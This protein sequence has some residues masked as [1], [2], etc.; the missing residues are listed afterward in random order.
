MAVRALGK[1]N[2]ENF[3]DDAFTRQHVIDKLAHYAELRRQLDAGET[4]LTSSRG[5]ITGFI[6]GWLGTLCELD[7]LFWVP[8]TKKEKRIMGWRN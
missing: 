8:K 4:T 3:Q 7:E 1:V 5:E 2:E 6:D